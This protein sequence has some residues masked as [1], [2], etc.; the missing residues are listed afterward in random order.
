MIYFV[1]MVSILPRIID[2]YH[3]CAGKSMLD[4]QLSSQSKVN[5]AVSMERHANWHCPTVRLPE[6]TKYSTYQQNCA[7][8]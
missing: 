4:A 2:L 1:E 5:K 3:C 8:N 6:H 7:G